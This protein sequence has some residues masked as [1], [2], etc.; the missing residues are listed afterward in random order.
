MALHAGVEVDGGQ[1]RI[2][3][4]DITSKQA[5]IVDFI[6]DTIQG[7]SADERM[8]SLRAILKENLA[9][10]D[11]KGL[12][13]ASS[14]P[15]RLMTLR[16][17]SVPFTKDEVIQKTIRYESEGHIPGVS[18]DDLIIDYLKCSETEDSAQLIIGAIDKDSLKQH[19][20][21][22]EGTELDPARVEI[23]ETALAT[24]LHVAHEELRIGKTLLLNMEAGHTDFVLIE[25]GRIIR[26]RS[27]ANQLLR[28]TLPALPTPE[29]KETFDRVIE[30]Q[31]PNDDPEAKFEQLFEEGE[32][33]EIVEEP[34]EELAI[35]VVSDEEFDQLK[36]PEA[37]QQRHDFN[38]DELVSR[39]VTEIQRTFAGYFLRNPIDRIV[40]SGKASRDLNLVGRLSET[41]EIPVQQLKVCDNMDS[42]MGHDKVDRC[43]ESGATAVGLALGAAGQSLT[44]FDLRKD[45]FR[46]ERRFAKLIPGLI[47]L[48][49]ILCLSSISHLISSH[50]EGQLRRAEYEAVR[51]NQMEVYKARF[52]E[53]PQ[54]RGK[55]TSILAAAERKINELKGGSS[56]NRRA[57]MDEYLPIIEMIEDV[58]KGVSSTRP[59]VYPEW[60]SM[61]ISGLKRE[62]QK[63]MVTMRVPDA[64][65]ANNVAGALES[66]TRFFRIE[67]D[68]KE[69]KEN[70]KL[71]LNLF[72]LPAVSGV[73][74][75]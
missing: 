42:S 53:E 74:E 64:I 29:E 2:A 34:L 14:I 11:R 57:R 56:G 52:G 22:F 49:L 50:R 35:A 44:S 45:E 39:L 68:I 69:D 48:G 27:T 38:S 12:D 75:R 43:N 5:V 13:F 54:L 36:D 60:L 33:P 51:N 65:A 18:I 28:D 8:D 24:S 9:E 3:V 21:I 16:D 72:L 73:R 46:Y 6:E 4:L 23:D 20:N 32:T 63:S 15:T 55:G 70:K 59:E 66:S 25:E 19:L 62:N 41:F 30:E 61:D 58:S 71:T 40:V 7:E 1:V 17:I 31:Y 37:G 67:D 26:L 10:G 47:L